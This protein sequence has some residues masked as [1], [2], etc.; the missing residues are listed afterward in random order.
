MKDYFKMMEYNGELYQELQIAGSPDGSKEYIILLKVDTQ[1]TVVAE[2]EFF[3]QN[4]K[5]NR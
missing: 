2:K 4:F 1:K 5:E 3:E